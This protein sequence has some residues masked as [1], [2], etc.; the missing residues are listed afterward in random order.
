MTL[1]LR[2]F[3]FY[4]KPLCRIFLIQILIHVLSFEVQ[5]DSELCVEARACH[6]SFLRV[7]QVQYY[8]LEVSVRFKT[9]S[10]IQ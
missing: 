2:C 1:Q 8:N 6:L 7:S 3:E 10:Y 9:S 5:V 4:N